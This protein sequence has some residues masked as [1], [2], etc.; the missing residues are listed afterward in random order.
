MLRIAMSH[1]RMNNQRRSFRFFLSTSLLLFLLFII[2]SFSV[3]SSEGKISK[4]KM[5][6]KM[7]MIQEMLPY[8][9]LLKKKVCVNCIFFI[10][11][12]S[13]HWTS[14]SHPHFHIFTENSSFA[15]SSA[16]AVSCF[17]IFFLFF[18]I[19]YLTIFHT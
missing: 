1:G 3:D 11:I 16:T 17:F 6:K 12:F 14:F 15:N 9:M 13:S 10:F 8:I 5:K 19:Y 18:F 7:K 4:I 2:L